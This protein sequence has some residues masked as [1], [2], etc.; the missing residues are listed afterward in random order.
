MG[1]EKNKK[2]SV[3]SERPEGN[4]DPQ[5]LSLKK[6][7]HTGIFLHSEGHQASYGGSA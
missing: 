7:E 4:T 5:E 3:K 1:A 2:V 6:G